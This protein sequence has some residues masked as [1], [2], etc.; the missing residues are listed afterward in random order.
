MALYL[1]KSLYCAALACPK[2]LWMRKN[3]PEQFD[4]SMMNQAILDA[5]NEVGDLAMGLFG[6]YVEVAY[7][8]DKS[9]ML[10]DTQ[11]LITAGTPVI[12]EAS[13]AFDGLFCSVDLLKNIGDGIVEIYEVKSA[14]GIQDYYYDDISYQYYVLTSLGF[15]VQTACIV[16]I[17]NAYVRIGE[18]DP[19]QLFQFAD[20]TDY[21]KEHIGEVKENIAALEDYMDTDAEPESVI[22]P[23][24]LGKNDR[25]GYF[26]YCMRTMPTPNV[27]DIA[28]LHKSTMLKYCSDGVVSFK[29]L[30]DSG[31][32][33][34]KYLQQAET[35]LH[36]L[37]PQ[38]NA[39]AI[40]S[41]LNTLS[42]PIYF[43]DFET[44]N[45]AIPQYDYTRPY[46]QI[47]FQYSLHYIEKEGGE[48]KH[49]EYL[50]YPGVD[51]RR[52]LAESLCCDI[53]INVCTTAYNMAFEKGRIREM[54]ELYPDLSEH[55]MNIHDNIRDLMIPFQRR[56]YY[57]R[58]MQGSYSIKYVLPA[59][60]PDDPSLDYH[61]LKGVHNG[62]EASDT[63]HKMA[64]MNPEELEEWRR[65]L[66]KYCELDTFAMVKV[67]EKL[68]EAAKLA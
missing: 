38:I 61:S 46:Q 59:L 22:C 63:F 56:E 18:L 13:F 17:N 28:G 8:S 45:P 14:T 51:P 23:N 47:T 44:F 55:L 66:L 49:K 1:S 31:K 20:M 30:V 60:F 26:T 11:K 52:G 10:N 39:E 9:C 35:E 54:A 16:Y 64:S 25:C 19:Q 12:A 34:G 43:L 21:V 7:N 6:D 67:L 57:T 68:K 27:F 62:G 42:Y 50:A 24:C 48:L 36:D 53:P 40:R 32:L 3:M 15:K 37:P 65:N 5:G 4:E 2:T 29:Q 41:F 58:E 33:K